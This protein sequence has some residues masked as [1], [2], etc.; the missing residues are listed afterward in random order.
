MRDENVRPQ[1][2]MVRSRLSFGSSVLVAFLFGTAGCQSGG[3]AT[4]NAPAPDEVAAAQPLDPT[5]RKDTRL[6]GIMEGLL[7]PGEWPLLNPFARAAICAAWSKVDAT[8]NARDAER[9]SRLFA[10]DVSFSFVQRGPSLDGRAA[11]LEHFREQ[12]PRLAPDLR[13]RTQI[14]AIRAVP[15]GAFTADGKVEILRHGAGGDDAPTILR[16]FAIFAVMS[17]KDEDW[18]IRMLRIYELSAPDAGIGNACSDEDEIRF[19]RPAVAVPPDPGAGRWRVAAAPCTEEAR[20]IV[21]AAA[22]TRHPGIG[23]YSRFEKEQW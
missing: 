7:T 19:R 16:T 14:G 23:R 6:S 21:A 15:P 10:D 2:R 12:F 22:R 8:W 3:A 13:H 5:T 1:T 9:F 18:S 17:G 4:G 11:I 20:S